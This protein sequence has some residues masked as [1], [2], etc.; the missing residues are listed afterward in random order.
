[1]PD[2]IAMPK[3][4][5]QSSCY[6]LKHGDEFERVHAAKHCQAKAHSQCTCSVNMRN[7]RVASSFQWHKPRHNRTADAALVF[8]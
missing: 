4:A 8:C 2:L 1:M 5:E 7:Q 3:P 6:A